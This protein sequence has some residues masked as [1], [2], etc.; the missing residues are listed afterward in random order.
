MK[1]FSLQVGEDRGLPEEGIIQAPKESFQEAVPNSMAPPGLRIY[2]HR[3]P[4]SLHLRERVPMSVCGK[5]DAES[6]SYW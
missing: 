5:G 6:P 1:G 2:A 4:D 3:Q